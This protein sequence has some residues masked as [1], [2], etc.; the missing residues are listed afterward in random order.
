MSDDLNLTPEER[1][2]IIKRRKQKQREAIEKE[3]YD[4]CLKVTHSAPVSLSVEKLVER[5]TNE[6]ARMFINVLAHM[7]VPH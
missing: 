4:L 3:V 7:P 2:L 5:M 1:D 6:T